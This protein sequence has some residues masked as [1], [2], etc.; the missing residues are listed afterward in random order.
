MF[1]FH[2]G[3]EYLSGRA[4]ECQ[5]LSAGRT[6]RLEWLYVVVGLLPVEGQNGED[7]GDAG[8]GFA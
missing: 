8:S 1:S 2:Y 5:Y 4:S 3:L 6:R 7:H